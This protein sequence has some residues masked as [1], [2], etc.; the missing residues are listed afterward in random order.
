MWGMA[1]SRLRYLWHMTLW[2]LQVFVGLVLFA[3]T[4]ELIHRQP[5][6]LPAVVWLAVVLVGSCAMSAYFM[7]AAVGQREPMTRRVRIAFGLAATA[8]LTAPV[9]SPALYPDN[10]GSGPQWLLLPGLLTSAAMAGSG[11]PRLPTAA[12]GTVLTT[13]AGALG[14]AIADTDVP[15]NAL[16]GGIATVVSCVSVAAQVWFWDVAAQVDRARQVEG[17]AAVADERLRFSAEL[18]DI[19]GHSLQVI[20]LKSELAA[21]LVGTDPAR[22][23]AEMREVETLAREALHD[24]REVAYGY[25]TVSL[26]TEIANATRVLAAAGVRCVTAQ[27]D[28]LPPLAPATERLL[29]LVVREATTNVIRHSRAGHAEITLTG[30]DGGVRLLVHNDAPLVSSSATAGGL[31]GLAE[32]FAAAGGTLTWRQDDDS[33][34]V[35]AEVGSR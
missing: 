14:A 4:L 27:D 22:A 26:T 1:V 32:R 8:A 20:A 30:H 7:I 17:A 13:V 24:T 25:R 2:T 15:E 5:A 6:P 19:Q 35:T 21:R 33:F 11:L 16:V 9:V 34:T 23:V 10:Y 12:V 3:A 31:A 29:G 28:G 18:H